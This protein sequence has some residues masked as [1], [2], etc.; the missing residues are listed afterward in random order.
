MIMKRDYTKFSI[1]EKAGMARILIVLYDE[2]KMLTS[3]LQ[4]KVEVSAE[5][6]YKARRY[7]EEIGLIERYK[8]NLGKIRP[9]RL[10]KRGKEVGRLLKKA[11]ELLIEEN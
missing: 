5:S 1:L 6:Y 2:K 3:A 7:L 8:L 9:Y 10:T 11:A 4:K